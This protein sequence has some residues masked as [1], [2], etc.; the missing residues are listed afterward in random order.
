ML[1]DQEI[2]AGKAKLRYTSDV[3]HEHN[4]CIRLAY[5]WLDAQVTIKSGAKKFRPL[6]HIIEKWAGRYVS[7]SDVEVAAIMHPRITGEYPN[8][9]LSAKIVLPNDRR[10]Q[11][12]GEAL[13]QG[14][15]DRMDRSIYSTVEA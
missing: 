1:T 13:T 10:L 2:E 8:Y 5:E 11:G 9:N 12:I 4:D 6:K 3:L 7:Q 14:Q 15:R